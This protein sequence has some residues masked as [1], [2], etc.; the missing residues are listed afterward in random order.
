MPKEKRFVADVR[1]IM[2]DYQ[3]G[4]G[5]RL[6]MR[7]ARLNEQAEKH[8][9]EIHFALEEMYIGF[10]VGDIHL[11]ELYL[12]LP[13]DYEDFEIIAASQEPVEITT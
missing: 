1:S 13:R 7:I 8:G 10:S 3:Q 12:L 5:G 9:L 2:R 6:I 11:D 4:K